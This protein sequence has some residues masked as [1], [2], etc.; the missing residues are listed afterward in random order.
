ME[1]PFWDSLEPYLDK[2]YF[3]RR[4]GKMKIGITVGLWGKKWEFYYGKLSAKYA[5]VEL[6]GTVLTIQVAIFLK[7]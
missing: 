6:S 1:M 5:I 3:I 7:V 2:E 4:R